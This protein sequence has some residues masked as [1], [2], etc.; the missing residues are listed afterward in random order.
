MKYRLIILLFF[1]NHIYSQDSVNIKSISLNQFTLKPASAFDIKTIYTRILSKQNFIS[2]DLTAGTVDTNIEKVTGVDIIYSQ[3]QAVTK[4]DS[5]FKNF[6]LLAYPFA[7]YSPETELAFGAGGMVYF[8]M[9]QKQKLNLSK[10]TLSAYYTTNKQYCFSAAPRIFFPGINKFYLEGGL[11]F[12]KSDL[13]FYGTGNNSPDIDSCNYT[14]KTFEIKAQVTNFRI[15]KNVQTGLIYEYSSCNI[16]NKKNNPYLLDQSIPGV[17]GGIIGGFGF[18]LI[19]DNRNNTSYPSSGEYAK[20]TAV[21]FRKPFGSNF[22]FNKYVV[23]LR[24]YFMPSESHIFAFQFFGQFSGGTPPF[25]GM[26]AVG[27]TYRMRGFFEGRYIDKQYFTAQ[28]E[29]RKILFW[30][31][32]AAA[33]YS[34]GE[35]ASSFTSFT[36]NGIKQSYGFGVRFVFDKEEKINLRADLGFAEGNKG[37]YFNLEEAF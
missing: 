25:F 35:V 5:A 7:F 26:P 14:A 8:K 22:T 12:S 11:N 28:A 13:V 24:K 6:G 30:R 18:A 9:A 23:D 10:I 1:L 29:Y 21:F 27:G 37:I 3:T 33:F 4:P 32:G 2:I 15:F 19:L 36:A 34:L 16:I 17:D 31:I 20:F